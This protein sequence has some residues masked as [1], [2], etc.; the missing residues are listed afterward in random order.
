M[1]APHRPGEPARARAFQ[2]IRLDRP[3]HQ[4]QGQPQ[5]ENL[6]QHQEAVPVVAVVLVRPQPPLQ[7]K[8]G[9]QDQQFQAKVP[10]VGFELMQDEIHGFREWRLPVD[11]RPVQISAQT[12]GAR[13]Q[14]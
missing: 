12:G 1:P 8:G 6:H 3:R 7:A 4:K 11:R 13:D 10:H 14:R 5:L 9:P 2:G